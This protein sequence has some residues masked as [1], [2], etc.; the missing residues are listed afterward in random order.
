M[1]EAVF[2]ERRKRGRPPATVK[3]SHL[4]VYVPDKYH[5]RLAQLA[6]K[7]DVSVSIVMT[8]VLQKLFDRP[9]SEQNK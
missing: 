7:H 8:R 3:K 5:D 1:S 2:V 9:I 4:T 6:L